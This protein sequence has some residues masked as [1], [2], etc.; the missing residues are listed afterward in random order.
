[1]QLAHDSDRLVDV[2]VRPRS[3]RAGLTV[4]TDGELSVRVHAAASQGA[5]NRECVALLA[6]ALGVPKSAVEIVRGERSRLKQVAVAGLDAAEARARL[7]QEALS[8]G[9]RDG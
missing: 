8:Q 4:D 2:R 6:K 9:G 7:Q 5:A 3:S 1:M